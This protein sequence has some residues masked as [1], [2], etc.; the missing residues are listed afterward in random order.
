M[1]CL[2]RKLFVANGISHFYL[3]ISLMFFI[4]YIIRKMKIKKYLVFLWTNILKYMW[5]DIIEETKDIKGYKYLH[6]LG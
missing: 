2:R 5:R 4:L 6:K 1:E 3:R